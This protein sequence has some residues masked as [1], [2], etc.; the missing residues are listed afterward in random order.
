MMPRHLLL[1]LLLL[2]S[3]LRALEPVAPASPPFGLALHGG[4]GVIA[5]A[6]LDADQEAAFRATLAAA[7]EA[8][9]DLLAAGGTALDAVETVVTRLESSPH[10]NAGHGAVLNADGLC[11]L[12][13]AIMDGATRAA[14]AVAGVRHIEHPIRLARAVMA[15]SPHV[16]LMGVGAETF[17]QEQGFPTVPNSFFVTPRRLEQLERARER[18][19]LGPHAARPGP[20]PAYLLGTVGC[21][22]LDQHGNLAAATSTGGMTNKRYGRVGDSPLIGAGT[23]ADNATA[24]LS[25]TGHGEFFIRGVVAHD[26]A[27][28]MAYGGRSLATASAETLAALTAAGG[29]GGWVA[30][31]RSG[32]VAMVFNTPGMYRASRTS[33]TPAMVE[34]FDAASP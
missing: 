21:V 2:W 8:G 6:T 13:A 24:A 28:R 20:A 29:T 19:A 32:E 14:G 1:P 3:P 22:A 26:V 5:R 34:I 23:F 16:L 27:A 17:A 15:R 10:F 25:A 9:Y 4:A 12:D 31:D 7:L 11:E 30:I 18:A 33:H